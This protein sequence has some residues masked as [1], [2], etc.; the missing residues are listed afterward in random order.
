MQAE[1]IIF[2]ILA[3]VSSVSALGILWV[4][5]VL[6]AALLLILCLL[7]LAGIFA[8][9]NAEFLAVTQIMVYAGGIL[10]LLLFGIMITA[11][12]TGQVPE[13]GSQYQG[14]G[15]MAGVGLLFLLIQS[16]LDTSFQFGFKTGATSTQSIGAELIT[17]FAA[18]F[19][20]SGLLLLVS[21]IGASLA[22]SY[23]RKHE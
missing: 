23:H 18:P 17:K 1:L 5:N 20:L 9:L 21:L 11:R 14:I 2:Y 16:L 3:F 8:V 22:A 7:S 19:E 4:K 10:V 12:I 6:H 15:L 13:V